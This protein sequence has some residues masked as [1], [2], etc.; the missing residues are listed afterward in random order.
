MVR[1]KKNR[2]LKPGVKLSF[3]LILLFLLIY[4][5]RNPLVSKKTPKYYLDALNQEM[6]RQTS[7]TLKTL[8]EEFIKDYPENKDIYMAYYCLGVFYSYRDEHKNSIENLTRSL[9]LNRINSHV[10]SKA[11]SYRALEYIKIKDYKDAISDINKAIRL[12]SDINELS[13]L[14]YEKAFAYNRLHEFNQ[15]LA[16]INKAKSICRDNRLLAS[17]FLEEAYSLQNQHKFKLAKMIYKE[18]LS[19][20]ASYEFAVNIANDSLKKIE[21]VQK[22]ID[23]TNNEKKKLEELLN[24]DNKLYY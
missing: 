13:F 18:V 1:K 14:Y 8:S 15:A 23:S 17:L 11:L 4:V 12:I 16:S 22:A 10:T 24:N 5:W 2:K 3:I 6:I 9:K 21:K 7:Y 20:F 19:K